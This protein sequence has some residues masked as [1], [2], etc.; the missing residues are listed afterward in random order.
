ML[1]TDWIPDVGTQIHFNGKPVSENLP[2]Q[3]FYNALLKIWLGEKP[4][5]SK[6]KLA[7][8]GQAE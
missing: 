4:T 8:L 1:R 6:L 7:L 2:D 3:V 5:D